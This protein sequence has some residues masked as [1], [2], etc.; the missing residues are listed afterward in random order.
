LN[1]PEVKLFP[2]HWR[3]YSGSVYDGSRIAESVA[4]HLI[5]S[6]IALFLIWRSRDRFGM[7]SITS[8]RGRTRTTTDD[9]RDG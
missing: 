9:G 6:A 4:A 8:W 1:L 7:W 2:W 3:Q 5:V